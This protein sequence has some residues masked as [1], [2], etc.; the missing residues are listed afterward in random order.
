MLVDDA[1]ARKN[2]HDFM[3]RMFDAAALLGTNAVCG[4]VAV[5]NVAARSLYCRSGFEVQQKY[6]RF[7]A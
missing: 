4:F 3:L 6:S 5:D 1:A 7:Y 2:K